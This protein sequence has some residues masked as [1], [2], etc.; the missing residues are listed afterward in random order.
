MPACE[1]LL[2]TLLPDALVFFSDEAH[3]HLSRYGSKQ[4]MRY[5][6]GNNP[7]ELHERPLHSDKVTVWCALSRV[8]VIGPY[9]FEEDNHGITVNS[10]RYVDMIF[11][12]GYLKAEVFKHRTTNLL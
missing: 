6:S 10:Q 9:F 3:F 7:R 4:N 1:T 12:W 5:W 11:L 2:E 8:G